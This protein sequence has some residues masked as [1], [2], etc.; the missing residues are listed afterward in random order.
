MSLGK[1]YYFIVLGLII[2]IAVSGTLSDAAAVYT[3]HCASYKTAAT[4]NEEVQRLLSLGYPAYYSELE[5]KDKGKWYRVYAGKFDNK[6]KA[7]LL[8]E[9]LRTNKV[10]GYSFIFRFPSS[11]S[12][13]E[14]QEKQAKQIKQ[15]KKEKQVKQDKPEKKS[16]KTALKK[17]ETPA[18]NPT[19]AKELTQK[20]APLIQENEQMKNERTQTTIP[21]MDEPNSGSPLY[22][23]AF[24]EMKQKNYVK[25][26]VTFKE[27][28]AR[29]DTTNEWGERALRHMADCHYYLGE[30]GNK[31]NLLIAVEFYKNTL[32]SFPDPKNENASTYYRL[33]RTYDY[34]QLY[35]EAIRYY[36][37]LIS[38]YSNSP[39][40]AEAVFRIGELHYITGNYKQ[41]IGKLIAYLK[42]DRDGNCA[43]QAYFIIADCFYKTNQLANAEIWFRDAQKRW[44][45]LSDVPRAVV[46]DLGVHKYNLRRYDEAINALSFYANTY[47][48]DKN[49]KE[50]LVLLANSYKA[51]GQISA[52][53]T[54]LNMIIDKYPESKEASESIILMASMG[55]EK[56]RVKVVSYLNNVHYYT[57]P[58]EAYDEVIMKN[59]TGEIAEAAILKKAEALQKLDRNKKASDVYLELLNMYPQSKMADEARKG[60]RKNSAGI[61]DEYFDKKDYL[62]VAYIYFKAYKNVPVQA[63]EF[64]QISKIV[65]SLK[66]LGL[67][68]DCLTLLRNYKNVCKDEQIL[69]KVMLNIAE[70]QMA[71]AKYDEAQK[72]LEELISRPSVK[73][74]GLIMAIKKNQAEISYQK[75][76]YDKT[77]YDGIG[78]SGQNINDPDLKT[79]SQFQTGKS[80]LKMEKKADAQKTFTEIKTASGPEGFWTKVVDYYVEDQKWWD[81]YGE[82]LQK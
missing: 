12:A 61:I 8:A 52:A 19:E 69:N 51:A 71:Q 50:V 29:D 47:S 4:A 17:E 33:A 27:F 16:P 46:W 35:T 38:K 40:A 44:A 53:V 41:A 82:R 42:K 57:H 1:K 68:E 63:D 28:I 30:K 6:R 39:Y 79:W 54:I 3:V 77:S 48:Q 21:E 70:V 24:G 81:K 34:M 14:K 10:V 56:P 74:S 18:A 15:D 59:L 55:V 13:E 20:P 67:T 31:K 25:A 78:R 9:T 2:L 66:E 80:Y 60:F 72:T 58:I 22:D 11:G 62:A 45:D 32:Q 76:L 7:T 36:E 65:L 5:I 26:L 23:Q 43:K 75:G 64:K 73:D 49:L 37:Q